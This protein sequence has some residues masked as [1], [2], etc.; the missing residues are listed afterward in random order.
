M[1]Y[2]KKGIYPAVLIFS[3]A[4]LA[5]LE[6]RLKFDFQV[7]SSISLTITISLVI[8]LE[9]VVPY[10]KDWS[11]SPEDR[12]MDFFFTMIL[13]PVIVTINQLLVKALPASLQMMDLTSMS[14]AVQ[15]ALPLLISEFLFY[16]S[17][18]LSHENPI[19]W[20][21]HFRHHQV[22][23]VYWMNSG[24]FNPAD[25]FLN[26]F[27]YCLPFAFFKTD[28]LA[29][30]YA[31]YFSATTGL[32]EHANVDFRAGA[33][34]YI[35]NTAELHRWHHSVVVEESQTNYGK[36]LSIFDFLF[37]TLK[38]EPKKNVAEVGVKPV[39]INNI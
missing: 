21:L 5:F 35:F 34:N 14:M 32:M 9:K 38:F 19:L 17:H 39:G 4:L 27:I 18:R 10:R 12:H 7:I 15:V 22:K 23:R 2:L 6:S 25:L 24:T 31:L 37:R 36:A 1:A 20:K 26:F 30:Q 16:F 29:I 11:Y 8:L 3:F 33:L 28:A 13:F